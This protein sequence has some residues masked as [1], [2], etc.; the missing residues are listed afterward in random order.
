MTAGA[1]AAGVEAATLLVIVRRRRR[2][3]RCDVARARVM[4][5]H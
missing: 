3:H 2:R 1:P 4:S 5:L